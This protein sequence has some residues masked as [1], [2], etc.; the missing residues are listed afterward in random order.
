MIVI[1]NNMIII[2]ISLNYNFDDSCYNNNMVA[3][4]PLISLISHTS[5]CIL[6]LVCDYTHHY[7]ILCIR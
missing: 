6:Y 2:C 1:N 4:L 7:T 5:M 3:S